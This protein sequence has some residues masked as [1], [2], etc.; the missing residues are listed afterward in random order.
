MAYVAPNSTVELFS[1]IGLNNNYDDSLYF[2]SNSAKDSYF[3]GLTKLATATAMS[4]NREQRGYIRVE[5]PM[6]TV[7]SAS[8][9]RFK[10]T[11]FENKWFYAFILNVEYINNNCT[12]INFEIDVLMTWMGVFTLGQC[13]IERQ[14]TVGDAIGANIADEGLNLGLYVCEDTEYYSLGDPVVA[15]Y[16]T[17]NADAGDVRPSSVQQGTYNPL[18]TYTFFLDSANIGLMETLLDTI[19][20]DNRADEIITMKLVPSNFV[21]NGSAVPWFNKNIS[22]PYSTIGGSQ[23]V[24]RNNKLYTYP[25]KYLRVE[26][27]EGQ[28]T[29]YKYE[30]FN[31]LPDEASTGNCE[32]QIRGVANSPSVAVMCTPL[33]YNGMTADY[34]Q[35]INMT[36]FPAIPWNVDAYKAYI[37][38]RDSTIYGEMLASTIAGAAQGALGGVIHGGASKAVAGAIGGASSGFVGGAK[39]L[40]S[41]TLNEMMAGGLPTRMPD[42]TRGRSESDIMMQSG[43]KYFWFRKMSITKN[44]AMMIDNF[45]DM[46]GYAI[47][48]HGV[49]NMNARPNWTYVKTIGCLVEGAIPAD[50][51]SMIEDIFNKGIRFW[52]NHTNIGNYSLNNAPT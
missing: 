38:Q 22:K 28:S 35:S 25:F 4:Y 32:F 46:Y 37:A 11:S 41:D 50:D 48:Q 13:F 18:A 44:Y 31:T 27:G 47:R 6:A 23:Y 34:D 8:Y 29:V 5:L 24:P 3:S 2:A 12:Q 43:L 49:P 51:A 17:Y 19:T 26:N 15:I 9:M 1:N 14:H 36:N 39:T 20:T 33:L 45:F 52:K 30:Y 7:I 40:L 42:Q 10:N 21:T 16:K